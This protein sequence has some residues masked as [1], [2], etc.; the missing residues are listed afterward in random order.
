MPSVSLSSGRI[1]ACWLVLRSLQRLGGEASRRDLLAFASRSSLRSGGL[2]IRDGIRLA[3]EGGLAH[4]RHDGLQLSEAGTDVLSFSPED[5]PTPSARRFLLTRLLLADPPTW[6][7]YWQGDP[8]ALDNVVPPNERKSLSDSGLLPVDDSTEDLDRWAF[9]RALGRVPLMSETAA[10]RK[11]LGD[12][13]EHLSVEFERHRLNGDGRPDLATQVQWLSRE[14]DA[15]GFDILSF[16]GGMGPDADRR[17]AIEVKTT[18]LP[19]AA[20][21]HFFLS[22]H[23]WNTAQR[24]GDQYVVHAW[25]RVDPGPPVIAREA[26]PLLIQPHMIAPHLPVAPGCAEQCRWETAEVYLPA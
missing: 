4:E 20:R 5:E 12:A 3:I 15:Y 6:V 14:S 19:R 11:R 21:L 10:H 25:T 7:A 18:S 23:E 8:A 9:W 1:T 24:L 13:G 17:V 2:P 22:A 16:V 26:G